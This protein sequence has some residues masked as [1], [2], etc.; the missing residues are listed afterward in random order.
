MTK[1]NIILAHHAGARLLQ[2]ATGRYPSPEDL[3]HFVNQG[4]DLEAYHASGDVEVARAILDCPEELALDLGQLYQQLRQDQEKKGLGQV[5]TPAHAVEAALD[6]VGGG[7][8]ERIIVPACGAGEFLLSAARRW[9]RAHITGV[10]IDP[11]AL[12]VARSR[13]V[14]A[15][16]REVQLLQ[17]NALVSPLGRGYD[18]VLGN[19]PWGGKMDPVHVESYAISPNKLLNSF[20]YFIE[21]AAR[22]LRAGGR[23][24]L[25]LPEAFIKVWCYQ[26]AREWLIQNFALTGLHYLPY[27]FRD[28]YAPAIIVAAVRLP[29]PVPKGIPVWIQRRRKPQRYNTLPAQAVQPL[30][31]NINWHRGM[32]AVWSK[33]AQ[34]AIYL[35]E[36][37]VASPLPPGEAVVDFS[38]GVVTGD[39]KRF[40]ADRP[41]SALHVPVLRARDVRPFQVGQPSSWLKY[42]A[43]ALKQAPPLAKYRV[44]AK[45]V[46]RFIAREI[47]AAA[48]YSGAPTLNNLNIIIP[49]RLPFSLECL[50][51]LL[52]SR[53][54]N[55]LYMYKF[56]T[57]KVLTRHLK[58]LPLQVGGEKEQQKITSLVQNL[59]AGQSEGK[60]L[61]ELIFDLYGLTQR[62]RGLIHEQHRRLRGLF[63]V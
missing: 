8:A 13:L 41:Q 40:V 4:G 9:P 33:C 48:D 5:F 35:R 60:R 1:I 54:I 18:L 45:I 14:L 46:Y 49:L 36:G 61:D 7:N 63:F 16:N 12:A 19:P 6:L 44:P 59:A 10:D 37:N 30:R 24:V 50:L 34:G 20:V 15:E 43:G 28:Y 42:Q 52:N 29:A 11:L 27:L 55:T 58:Q 25:L 39:N 51:A 2:Q 47:M 56:F 32:E 3:A 62:E 26:G 23:M 57:G 31:I 38:L 22:L 21:L 53:L 17:G